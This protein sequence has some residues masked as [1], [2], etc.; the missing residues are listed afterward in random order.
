MCA[1]LLAAAIVVGT[2]SGCLEV[3]IDGDVRSNGHFTGEAVLAVPKH[4]LNDPEVGATIAAGDNIAAD[5]R[6]AGVSIS[7]IERKQHRYAVEAA[8][9]ADL[10]LP[11]LT[12]AYDRPDADSYAFAATMALP[13]TTLTALA[14]RI[15]RYSIPLAHGARHGREGRELARALA[16]RAE[17]R[18]RLTFAGPV[19][20]TNGQ[21][22]GNRTVT[23]TYDYDDLRAGEPQRAYAFGHVPIWRRGWD[24]LRRIF[25]G[26][27]GSG[28]P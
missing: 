3:E 28:V 27:A 25:D 11:W 2:L 16:A 6:A 1:R 21:R 26:M 15:E 12:L 22:D 18:L 17:V 10:Q 23:W 7:L 8:H 4:L 14:R 13:A 9:L 24:A 19:S 5:W 20:A